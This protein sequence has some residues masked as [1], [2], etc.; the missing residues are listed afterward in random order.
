MDQDVLLLILVYL[1]WASPLIV[2]VLTLVGGSA[3]GAVIVAVV[4]AIR[5]GFSRGKPDET[6]TEVDLAEFFEGAR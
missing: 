6:E 5:T 2:L 3:L 1:G 4:G